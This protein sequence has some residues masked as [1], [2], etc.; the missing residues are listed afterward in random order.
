MRSSSAILALA[1]SISGASADTYNLIQN[2]SASNWFDSFT[3]QTGADPT[4]GF[5]NYLSQ[6]QAESDG[7][8]KTVGGKVFIGVDN[9]TTLSPTGTGRNSV[10]IM[11]NQAYTHALV[12]AD[13]AHIPGSECGSWPAF[14][15]LG[16]GTWPDNGE[17]DIIEGINNNTAD[18]MSIHSKEGC[19]VTV[20]QYGQLG[21]SGSISNCGYAGG[22]DGCT[23]YSSSQKS[24]GTGFNKA[25][26]GIYTLHWTGSEIKVWFF[27][28]GTAPSD[29]TDG[30]EPNPNLWGTPQAS[31]AGCAFDSYFK[32]MSILFNTD[33]CGSWAGQFWDDSPTC[34]P[35]AATCADYV[36]ANPKVFSDSY[37]LINS[38]R[39]YNG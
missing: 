4:G 25:G 18:Q 31:F 10:K 11:S 36:A 32:D 7:L 12:I 29:I 39:V 33:F 2:Y 22:Y 1:A 35:H 28:H 26:G 3:T 30:G 27:V 14:W 37:W 8:Y 6:A 34:S 20:G 17:I 24:Y 23:V 9:T 15:M 21:T 5:V 38:V 16:S 19:N 13:L